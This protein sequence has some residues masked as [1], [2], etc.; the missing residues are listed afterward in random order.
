LLLRDSQVWNL[1]WCMFCLPGILLLK[2]T[3]SS[4]TSKQMPINLHLVVR[5]CV[6]LPSSVPQ[7]NLAIVLTHLVHDAIF[8]VNL[9]VCY[10]VISEN[11]FFDFLN[12]SALKIF[13]FQLCRI[14]DFEWKSVIL[15]FHIEMNTLLFSIGKPVGILCDNFYWL[16]GK[17]SQIF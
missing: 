5:F 1:P 10:P 2:K 4:P 17:A 16:Q 14:T 7:F 15:R 3:Y 12:T 6:Y 11:C 8:T 9:Y 13:L